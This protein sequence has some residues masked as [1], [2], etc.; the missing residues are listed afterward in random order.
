MTDQGGGANHVVAEPVVISEQGVIC[1]RAYNI[2]VLV[3]R[4]C[5]RYIIR[6]STLLGVEE[7]EVLSVMRG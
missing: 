2:A 7:E 5:W 1:I 4:G 3:S 6:M